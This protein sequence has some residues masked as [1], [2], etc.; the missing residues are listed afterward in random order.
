[1]TTCAVTSVIFSDGGKNVGDDPQTKKLIMG[2]F[3]NNV[4]KQPY[5]YGIGK[6]VWNT[7]NEPKTTALGYPQLCCVTQTS[8][9]FSLTKRR[10]LCVA[11]GNEFAE[12]SKI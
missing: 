4:F 11:K 2:L 9:V 5:H 12:K 7:Q 6:I 8:L 10:S 3:K 1:M